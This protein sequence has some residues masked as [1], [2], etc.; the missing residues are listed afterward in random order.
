MRKHVLTVIVGVVVGVSLLL[1]MFAF[2]VRESEVAVLLRFGKASSDLPQPGY[3]FKLPW[4][5]EEVRKFD[6]RINVSE[7]RFEETPTRDKRNITLSLCVGW[8]VSDP[9]AFNQ[10]FG[11]MAE[12]DRMQQAWTRVEGYVRDSALAVMGQ[13]DLN[14]LV[15]VDRDKLKYDAIEDSILQ[16]SNDR[17]QKTYGISFVLL[18]LRRLELPES[19]T[20]NV[21]KR[22][23]AERNLEATKIQQEGLANAAVIRAN[24]TTEKEKL[25]AR[26]RSEAEA[27]KG[28]GDAEAAQHF[29]VFA[30]NPALAIYLRKIRALQETLKTKTTI[31]VD[32]TI[33]PFDLFSQGFTGTI[34]QHSVTE[35]PAVS[36]GPKN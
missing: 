9:L 13:H 28:Q 35:A 1:Y 23:I 2:Q 5:I 32:P 10:N 31:I 27:L 8:R 4:P 24:A 36:P 17:A 16:A 11:R 25:L 30:K 15:S 22:M 6:S 18:K 19:A 34:N 26:A 3:H 7:G 12:D 29:G 14:E 20:Q 33:P 21:Y